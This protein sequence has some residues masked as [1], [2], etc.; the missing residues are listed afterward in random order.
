VEES[1]EVQQQAGRAQNGVSSRERRACCEIDGSTRDSTRR[2]AKEPFLAFLSSRVHAPLLVFYSEA[3]GETSLLLRASKRPALLQY[4]LLHAESHYSYS[5][6]ETT[7]M[8]SPLVYTRRCTVDCGA[9]L[10]VATWS[11]THSNM[12]QQ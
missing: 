9:A 6:H 8:T 1:G 10:R 12:K 7:L 11:S 3:M 5:P 2:P 4:E